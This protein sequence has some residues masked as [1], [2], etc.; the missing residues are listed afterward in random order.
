MERREGHKKMKREGMDLG[1]CNMTC[2][3]LFFFIK[4]VVIGE[5]FL[6]YLLCVRCNSTRI[7]PRTY[8]SKSIRL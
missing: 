7:R 4:Q 3:A 6:I 1:P 5:G 8:L 2:G